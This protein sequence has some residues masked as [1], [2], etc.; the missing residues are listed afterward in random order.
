[1]QS[2]RLIVRVLYY[3]YKNHYVHTCIFLILVSVLVKVEG[4][5]A[6]YLWDVGAGATA[7][8]WKMG[9]VA[10][11]YFLYSCNIVYIRT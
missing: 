8:V 5:V 10:G 9:R 7:L 3:K 4:G 6:V 2:S 11:Y 1:M